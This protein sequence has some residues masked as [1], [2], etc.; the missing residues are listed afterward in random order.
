VNILVVMFDSLRPDHLGFNG[1]EYVRTP[2]ID[3]LAEESAV[4]GN[5]IVEF[6]ITIPSRTALVTGNYTFTNRRWMPLKDDDITLGQKLQEVGYYNCAFS[7]TPFST[8]SNMDRGF[9]EFH[10]IPGGKCHTPPNP[11]RE[12]DLSGIH[13]MPET[14]PSDVR[15]YTNSMKSRAELMQTQGMYFP[16]IIT[17]EAVKWLEDAAARE[18]KFMLWLDY[19]DP[20]EPWDP[21]QPYSEMYDPGYRGKFIPMPDMRADHCTKEELRHIV[22]QYDGCV[23]QVDEQLGKL[24]ACLEG[25]ALWDDTIVVLV[26]DHGEPFGEHGTIRKFF[27]PVYDE[28]SKMV[29]M[30][31]DPQSASGGRKIGALVQNTD[32]MPTLLARLGIESHETDGIDLNPLIRGEVDRVRDAAYSGA[33]QI[34][35][36]VRTDEWKLI[37]N[38]GEKE[39]ELF[40]L[41]DDP[42][43][44]NNLALQEPELCK[45]LHRQLW[46]FG[47]RWSKVLAWRERPGQMAK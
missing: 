4:F 12:V 42:G 24:R 23:T 20:H 34:R 2:N 10:W 16:D 38:R 44:K 33:F 36:S 7:D 43:E 27:V 46:E 21:P 19:F 30:I 47:L 15:Y 45:K 25:L 28:L 41:P 17:R 18:R 37:D 32:L 11:D 31:R 22:A 8:S 13:F 9:D 6:P 1:H 39:T 3:A 5:A 14:A 26:S 29:F 40:N 35:G